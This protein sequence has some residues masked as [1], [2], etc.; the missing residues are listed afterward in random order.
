LCITVVPIHS[1]QMPRWLLK[2]IITEAG[3]TEDE[4]R[5]LLWAIGTRDIWRSL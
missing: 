2:K 4:F 1:K 5:K 3:F